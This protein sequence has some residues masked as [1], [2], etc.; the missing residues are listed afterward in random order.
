MVAALLKLRPWK[1]VAP[2]LSLMM[3]A[4]PPMLLSWKTVTPRLVLRILAMPAVLLSWNIVPRPG[5]G[6]LVFWMMATP[7]VLLFCEAS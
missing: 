1:T 3:C 7:A 5:N 4:A 6:L 2:K